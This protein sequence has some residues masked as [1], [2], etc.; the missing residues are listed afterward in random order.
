MLVPAASQL[1]CCAQLSSSSPPLFPPLLSSA[2]PSH[3]LCSA[4]LA[5]LL[6]GAG[7]PRPRRLF[8]HFQNFDTSHRLSSQMVILHQPHHQWCPATIDTGTGT[9]LFATWS[10]VI[11]GHICWCHVEMIPGWSGECIQGTREGGPASGGARALALQ[12]AP[13]AQQPPAAPRAVCRSCLSP[14]QPRWPGSDPRA[15]MPRVMSRLGFK[16]ERVSLSPG[17]DARPAR[18]HEGVL[19]LGRGQHLTPLLLGSNNVPAPGT[20]HLESRAPT[21]ESCSPLH[22]HPGEKPS[23]ILGVDIFLVCCYR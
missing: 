19:Q 1:A 18:H 12:E 21:E 17:A 8:L 3:G 2:S 14:V 15:A 4:W 20:S 16:P 23:E 6:C 7:L 5:P 22:V 9:S 11:H 13:L 10:Q